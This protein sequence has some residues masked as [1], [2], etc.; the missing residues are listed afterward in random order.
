MAEY[1]K[2]SREYDTRIAAGAAE[3]EKD[4]TIW[5]AY[6]KRGGIHDDLQDFCKAV[7]RPSANAFDYD[8]EE[9]TYMICITLYNTIWMRMDAELTKLDQS[10][11]MVEKQRQD[12]VPDTRTRTYTEVR[13]VPMS[14]KLQSEEHNN[15][16]MQSL[17]ALDKFMM[18]FKMYA[19][20]RDVI[21]RLFSSP[22][23]EACVPVTECYECTEIVYE[24]GEVEL[25][26]YRS[27]HSP[28]LD[29]I[30]DIIADIEKNLSLIQG[31]DIQALEHYKQEAQRICRSVEEK[32][33]S[34]QEWLL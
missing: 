1:V 4:Q 7:K 8:E 22:R 3:R 25:A 21:A 9:K 16:I 26:S 28:L 32:I 31:E 13:E 11:A 17:K 29:I 30:R 27:V 10:L 15:G 19:V 23:T 34:R 18:R 12:Y 20:I 14:R 2:Q 5:K 6:S 24:E 33:F